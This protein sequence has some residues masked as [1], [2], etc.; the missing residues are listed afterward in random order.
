MGSGTDV[1]PNPWSG[2]ED[3]LA[4]LLLVFYVNSLLDVFFFL[5]LMG[6]TNFLYIV[7]V[8]MIYF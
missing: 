7:S 5:P 8:D 2:D 1:W 4:S 3:E 6:Y